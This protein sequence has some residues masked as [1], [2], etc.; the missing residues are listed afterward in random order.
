MSVY[1]EE[2]VLFVGMCVLGLGKKKEKSECVLGREREGWKEKDIKKYYI[3]YVIIYIFF[4]LI[5]FC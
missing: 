4:M 3:L 1:W 2:S 5:Y